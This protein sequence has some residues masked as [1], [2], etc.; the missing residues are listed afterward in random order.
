[1][2]GWY[3]WFSDEFRL[4]KS[5]RPSQE[6]VALTLQD[7]ESEYPLRQLPP[8]AEVTRIAPSPT[9]RP[10]IGTALQ[11]IIDRAMAN[12]AGG[13]FLLRIEDTDQTRLVPG[14][15]EEIV[16]ALEWLGTRPD[17]GTAFGGSY[18]SYTQS[19]RLPLSALP[20]SGSS[21]TATHSIAS[22]P[23]SG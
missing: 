7:Y 1:M 18:G 13:R 19:E 9:G 8:G 4:R 15:V 21:S 23:W 11:A 3:H 16:N 17:E 10:H 14:A 20:R 6:I 12:Q 2:P 5:A 22:A